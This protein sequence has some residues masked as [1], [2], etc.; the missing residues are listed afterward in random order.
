M[1]HK[2]TL[3]VYVTAM[4]AYIS[5]ALFVPAITYSECKTSPKVSVCSILVVKCHY[6]LY[7]VAVS[8]PSHANATLLQNRVSSGGLFNEIKN[9]KSCFNNTINFGELPTKIEAARPIGELD[10]EFKD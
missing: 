5:G 2:R 7:S 1:Y 6:N 3:I 9:I 10:T 8:L 4:S